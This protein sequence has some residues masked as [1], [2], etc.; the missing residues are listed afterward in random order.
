MKRTLSAARDVSDAIVRIPRTIHASKRVSVYDLAAR[1]GYFEQHEPV[2]ETALGQR[3]R[4]L[5]EPVEE[6]LVYSEDERVGRGWG[7]SAAAGPDAGEGG[8]R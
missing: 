4:V 7:R 8:G 6:W 1:T 5:L 2:R 3:L